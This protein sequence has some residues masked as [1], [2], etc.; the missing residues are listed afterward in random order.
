MA[1]RVALRR[2]RVAMRRAR[3]AVTR[4]CVACCGGGPPSGDWLVMAACGR[5]S[6]LCQSSRRPS[7]LVPPNT[8]DSD[9]DLL[10][11]NF[12]Y[13]IANA[14]GGPW[15]YMLFGGYADIQVAAPV[16][17]RI[18]TGPGCE[19]APDL[20]CPACSDPRCP[21]DETI[22]LVDWCSG[23]TSLRYGVC[24]DVIQERADVD[25]VS[26]GAVL[27]PGGPEGP[28]GT[29]WQA[30][31]GVA[32]FSPG[33]SFAAAGLVTVLSPGFNSDCC[34]AG[35]CCFSACLAQYVINGV[36]IPRDEDRRH[37]CCGRR[38]SPLSNISN[39][40]ITC[41]DGYQYYTR[42]VRG[43]DVFEVSIVSE[44]GCARAGESFLVAV[45]AV[46]KRNGEI[47]S[48]VTTMDGISISCGMQVNFGGFSFLGTDGTT[49]AHRP[50]M[51]VSCSE[52]F[53]SQTID[54]P[55]A[56]TLEAISGSVSRACEIVAPC[57]NRH[58]Y[59]AALHCGGLGA[60]GGP[61]GA[62]GGGLLRSGGL[63]VDFGSP[64]SVL[65]MSE[66][67]PGCGTCGG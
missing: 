62:G 55:S 38:V 56:G 21:M 5:P 39:D 60:P 15:C 40:C 59:P 24:N 48:D 64:E 1:L 7:I 36:K 23:G 27:V 19:S 35:E 45:R 54:R 53:W 13:L 22:R 58:I 2:G 44:G 66:P 18:G 29:Q 26:W 28:E 57:N 41:L 3:A 63:V 52:V 6:E 12:V 50:F 14:P 16:A 11:G 47:T 43:S 4:A 17:T 30:S 34:R 9:G 25:G 51:M 42:A 67:V 8:R 10:R 61:G 37:C 20:R 49:L 46:V 33:S 32:T 65:G 31:C